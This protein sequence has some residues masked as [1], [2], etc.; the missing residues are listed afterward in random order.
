MWMCLMW[1]LPQLNHK[2]LLDI[3]KTYCSLQFDCCIITWLS[4]FGWMDLGIS[5][6]SQ[7]LS[8]AMHSFKSS[9][10]SSLLKWYF[11]ERHKRGRL[12]ELSIVNDKWIHSNYKNL[13]VTVVWVNLSNLD[14]LVDFPQNSQHTVQFYGKNRLTNC[15]HWVVCICVCVAT[16]SL[17]ETFLS[18]PS[19]V[20]VSFYEAQT[21]LS[22]CSCCPAPTQGF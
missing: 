16:K 14:V 22:L 13:M 1:S 21:G 2:L 9:E 4:W 8:V 19:I 15:E 6:N 10:W 5:L 17:T 20:S 3:H 7:W 11:S 12:M 18:F